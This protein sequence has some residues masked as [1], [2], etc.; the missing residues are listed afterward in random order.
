MLDY[1]LDTSRCRREQ[2]LGF[3]GQEPGS[4]GGCDVCDGRV[5]KRGFWKNRITANKVGDD[6][7]GIFL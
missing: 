3:L 6:I 1:A 2:L 4:C 5:L 7:S